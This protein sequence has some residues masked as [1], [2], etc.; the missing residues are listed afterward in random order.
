MN[1]IVGV[2]EAGIGTLAGPLVITAAAFRWGHKFNKMIRDS[3][4]LSVEQ[5]E[6]LIDEIYA[7][8]AWVITAV[9]R[10]S[11]I[12]CSKGVWS[13]W[14]EVMDILLWRVSAEGEIGKVNN[15]IVDG[16]RMVPRFSGV[17]Y[18]VKADKRFQQVSA[19]S[20]VAKYVQT[21]AMEDIHEQFPGYGFDRHHGYG[22]VEHREA[23][24]RLGPTHEHRAQ[25][26]PVKK[27]LEALPAIRRQEF[28]TRNSFDQ[29]ITLTVIGGR[30]NG[31]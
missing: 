15:V 16:T 5:R 4:T 24:S 6:N 2:D 19:A 12:N 28:D 13:V 7:T 26:R 25:Y 31:K 8:S 11:H 27:A 30:P 29:G 21:S 14:D 9:A 10:S 3:K 18:E 23:L 1:Y 20:I 17:R 22:T